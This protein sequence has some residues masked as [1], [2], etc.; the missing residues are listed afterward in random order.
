[1]QK[2]CHK[3]KHMFCFSSSRIHD[4]NIVSIYAFHHRKF[5]YYPVFIMVGPL[6]SLYIQTYPFSLLNVLEL[7]LHSAPFSS[8]FLVQVFFTAGVKILGH[9]LR[10][11][12]FFFDPNVPRIGGESLWFIPQV[13]NNFRKGFNNFSS[14]LLLV[15]FLPSPTAPVGLLHSFSFHSFSHLCFSLTL[16]SSLTL[17]E[18][19]YNWLLGFLLEGVA[20]VVVFSGWFL[21]RV[22]N[23]FFFDGFNHLCFSLILPSSLTFHGGACN[24]VCWLCFGKR[25]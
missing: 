1:M 23:S 10:V 2:F 5:I 3:H 13:F 19:T 16:I 11:F 9:F 21:R 7:N 20:A 15:F 24:Q 12:F 22:L 4:S 8:L 6:V 25:G 17:K 14:P 18:C